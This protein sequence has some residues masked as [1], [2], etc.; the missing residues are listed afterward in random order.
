MTRTQLQTN[1][2]RG[3]KV[4]ELKAEL[5]SRGLDT[6]GLKA[7]L[8]E[9]LTDAVS[10]GESTSSSSLLSIYS[11][12]SLPPPNPNL[13]HLASQIYTLPR[14]LLLYLLLTYLLHFD[15]PNLTFRLDPT[16]D[17]EVLVYWGRVGARVLAMAVIGIWV[18]VGEKVV[19]SGSVTK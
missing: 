11:S 3:M 6:K 19:K 12:P 8:A 18:K 13:T 9:R 15:L 1:D 16:E 17:Y 14:L 7:V 5:K 4:V 2:V 10:V